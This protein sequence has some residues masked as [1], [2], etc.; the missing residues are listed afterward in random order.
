MNS[1]SCELSVCMRACL[2][3]DL[4]CPCVNVHV[5]GVVRATTCVRTL[6]LQVVNSP[7]NGMEAAAMPTLYAVL[8]LQQT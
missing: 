8:A 5:S 3:R 7:G 6:G 2:Y 1:D 4:T